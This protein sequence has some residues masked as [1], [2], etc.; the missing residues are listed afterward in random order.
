MKVS[1]Y[2]VLAAVI[3]AAAAGG[4]WAALPGVITGTVTSSATGLPVA[5]AKVW[6]AGAGAVYTGAA[7]KYTIS[8]PAGYVTL[9]SVT[10]GYTSTCKPKFSITSGQAKTRNFVL[11]PK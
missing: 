11:A 5:R 7:G 8:V 4:T 2:V 1:R 3:L 9:C 6:V 10:T